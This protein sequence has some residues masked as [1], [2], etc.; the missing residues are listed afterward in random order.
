MAQA[1][2]NYEKKGKQAKG[3]V[4]SSL[5]P[6][7]EY[8]AGKYTYL[9]KYPFLLPGAWGSR[10]LNYMKETQGT[11]NNDAKESIAIGNQR[12]ELLKKYKIIR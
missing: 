12:I 2:G 4:A 7:K 1:A 3:S 5:V 10:N 6:D 9:E 11:K 8:M